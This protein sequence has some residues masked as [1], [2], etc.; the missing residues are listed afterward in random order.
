M[1][2]VLLVVHGLPPRATGGT[3]IYTHDLALALARRDDVEV[4]ILAREDDPSRAEY[5]LRRTRIDAVPVH[6]VNNTFSACRSFEDSYRSAAIRHVAARV[7]DRVAPD[8]VHVQ[9]LTCLST[10][11]VEEVAAR[12][13]PVVVTLNDYWWMCHRGQL[14]DLD[15]ERCDGP[16]RGCDRC[17]GAAAGAGPAMY[18][19]GTVLRRAARRLPDAVGGWLHRRVS[20]ATRGAA[21]ASLAAAASRR[22]REHMLHIASQVR[23]F[24]APSRTL[25]DRF[26]DF[27]I[28]RDR[29]RLVDQGIHTAPFAGLD[30][31]GSARLRIGFLGSL[32]ASKAPHLLLEAFSGLPEGRATLELLGSPAPYHG[33]DSYRKRLAPLLTRPGVH[34]RGA[35]PHAEVPRALAALDVLV[36]PS[37]WLENAP[38]VIREA[39]AAGVPVV[40]SRLGGMAEMVDHEVSGLLF[41]PGDAAD[42]ERVLRRL[43][44]E[45]GL[46]DRLRQGLPEVMSMDEDADQLVTLYR[47][48]TSATVRR[49]SL[50]AVVLNWRTPHDAVLAVRSLRSSRR[51]PDRVVVIDNGSADGSPEVL[52]EHL[53]PREELLETGANLGFA[54]GCNVGIRRVLARG[55][56]AVLLLNADAILDPD[57]A[58]RLETALRSDERIGIAGPVVVDR[59][60]P[61]RIDTAGMSFSRRTGR[62]HHPDH[63]RDL[64]RGGSLE[65]RRVD[66]VSGC[67]MLVRREVLDEVGLLDESTFFSFEDLDLCL[68]AAAAGW[69]TLRVGDA[70]C[71]HAGSAAIG[72]DSADRIAYGARNHLRM[73]RR[74]APLPAPLSCLRAAAVAALSVAAGA[75]SGGLSGALAAVSGVADALRGRSGPLRGAP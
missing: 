17:L 18:A 74:V 6:L 25:Y 42:L 44:E 60:V 15:M 8:V 7:L 51:R 49:P 39:Y 48:L 54:A 29:L 30:R 38:F 10:E 64:P 9:H 32:L 50:E 59:S 55:A 34:H 40:A 61:G 24:L 65:T 73:L 19:G 63:G 66:G 12:G 31:T 75:R 62:M 58:G 45:P 23:L 16:H 67:A 56:D 33:D 47:E 13:L 5:G 28:P 2:R 41:S 1:T 37:V 52:R 21:S 3:E 20:D 26:V 11:L 57:A 14:L 69:T 53:A 46:L 43:L 68:R 27:G 72:R 70:L 35:V 4:A 36:V 22:R 71:Y